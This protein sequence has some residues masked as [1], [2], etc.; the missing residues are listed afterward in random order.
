M[1]DF[2]LLCEYQVSHMQC[3][4]SVFYSNFSLADLVQRNTSRFAQHCSSGGMGGGG[5]GTAGLSSGSTTVRYHMS[6]S[7]SCH[8]KS[9]QPGETD[10]TEFM[11]SLRADVENDITRSGAH[12]TDGGDLKL[13]GFY[14]RYVTVGIQGR[15]ELSGWFTG[16]NVYTL[17]AAFTETSTIEE[18]PFIELENVG[19]R[20]AGLYHV[21][22][23]MS[24]DQHPS[25]SDFLSIGHRA[26]KES[27]EKVRQKLL[28][29]QLR[30]QQFV[31]T[32][33]YAEIFVL[34]RIPPEIKQRWARKMGEKFGPP[35]EYDRYEKVYFLNDIALR[36]Y[37][38][39]GAEFEILKAISA[40]EVPGM[41]FPSLRGPYIAKEA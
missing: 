23:F 15:V 10:V 22:P 28:T 18:Q 41:A 3:K 27:V 5:T 2:S 34:E 11:A 24:A 37:R 26:L 38:D 29:D 7:Y 17:T 30:K 21:V 1:P 6:V 20:P 8:I 36:M 40:D 14:F 19:R 13:S 9:S 31:Q 35:A 16:V 39:A 4:P 32:L 25:A 33:E 12:I